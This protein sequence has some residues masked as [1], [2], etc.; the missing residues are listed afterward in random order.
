MKKILFVMSQLYN[1][2]A[3]RSLVNLLNELPADRY[4]IDLLLFRP[5]GMFLKQVPKNVNILPTPS[6]LRY[7]YTPWKELR[8][9]P[10]R[11]FIAD[12]VSKVMTHDDDTR[13]GY[14]WNHFYT[15]MIKG[16]PGHYDVAVAYLSGEQAAY[17]DEK[18]D[19]DRKY[20]WVHNDYRS[21]GYSKEIDYPHF[22]NM[23]GIIS[24]SQHCV[25]VLKE[26][27]PEFAGKIHLLENITSSTVVRQRADEFMPSE[28]RE[29]I[30]SLLT[31]GRLDEQKG[32]D[33][34]IHAASIMKRNGVD[35]TWYVIGGGRYKEPELRK[36]ISDLD[37]EDRFVLLGTKP[38]PYPYIKN[39]DIFVQPSRYEG[40]SVVLDE[41]K[42]L[43]KPILVT[44]Y[45][46]AR[47]QVHDGQE[48]VVVALDPEAIAEGLS[49][50]LHDPERRQALHDYLA[51]REYGNADIIGKYCD[52]FD[53]RGLGGGKETDD[54]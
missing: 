11:R 4:Q 1:G 46:T 21:A 35:F 32:I 14:R 37:V 41:A 18:V 23:D 22:R 16:L 25:D 24:I 10:F 28:Y 45:P 15:H 44:N 5:A 40:K 50:L 31:V 17:V 7:C 53:G 49:D 43:A 34:A 47:D 13:R 12:G 26:V 27:F 20:V 39:C 19:A 48:A 38:N 51:A 54:E 2:G 36:L 29:G 8:G 52:L 9:V 6:E 33:L 42:I 3:E 30:P